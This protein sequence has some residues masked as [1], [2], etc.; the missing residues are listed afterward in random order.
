MFVDH[1]KI[2]MSIILFHN[3]SIEFNIPRIM[4]VEMIIKKSIDSFDS[5]GFDVE[6]RQLSS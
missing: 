2:L 4:M 5:M 1:I 6:Q 3:Q